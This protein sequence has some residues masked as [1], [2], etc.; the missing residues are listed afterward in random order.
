MFNMYLF[1]MVYNTPSIY[2]NM[3][4]QGEKILHFEYIIYLHRTCSGIL[5]F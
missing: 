3:Y 1:L 5:E 4:V 2:N